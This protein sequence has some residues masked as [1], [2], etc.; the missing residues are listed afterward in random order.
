MK[1]TI[2]LPKKKTSKLKRVVLGKEVE[3]SET[4][5]IIDRVALGGCVRA[6][7][8]FFGVLRTIPFR[9]QKIQ[10]STLPKPLQSSIDQGPYL[11]LM[12]DGMV[13][14][15]G[16]EPRVIVPEDM[17]NEHMIHSKKEEDTISDKGT[18]LDLTDKIYSNKHIMKQAEQNVKDLIVPVQRRIDQLSCR[19][20]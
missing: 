3:V 17:S 12:G 16:S 19:S 18:S 11:N 4:K 20:R 2:K 7:D 13:T 6:V 1:K 5:N 10:G 14:A 15:A 9:R 8:E